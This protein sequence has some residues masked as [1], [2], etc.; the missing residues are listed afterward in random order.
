[1]PEKGSLCIKSLLTKH[2][3]RSYTFEYAYEFMSEKINGLRIGCDLQKRSRFH[4]F[5]HP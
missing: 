2:Y 4:R 5:S 3:A 1:M